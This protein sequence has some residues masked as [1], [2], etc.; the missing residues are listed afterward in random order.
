MSPCWI[1][2][3]VGDSPPF[4]WWSLCTPALKVTFESNIEACI[5]DIPLRMHTN[6]DMATTGKVV[7][8]IET[9]VLLMHK[10]VYSICKASHGLLPNLLCYSLML[11]GLPVVLGRCE[12]CMTVC[13]IFEHLI[14]WHSVGHELY[15]PH[16]DGHNHAAG[17]C[18]HWVEHGVC[19]DLSML[20]VKR[21]TAAVCISHILDLKYASGHALMPLWSCL[22]AVLHSYLL[23][24]LPNHMLGSAI[25][26]ATAVPRMGLNCT[27][28]ISIETE[29]H[30]LQKVLW[31]FSE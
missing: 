22:G 2:E 26:I 27:W 1:L 4:F 12:N 11:W 16:E 18:H 5:T 30:L 25:Y 28:L 6:G 24:C 10:S 23:V 21:L 19:V 8:A 14:T 29:Q 15:G 3:F 17:C 31:Y 7:P 13:G 20:L 9:G